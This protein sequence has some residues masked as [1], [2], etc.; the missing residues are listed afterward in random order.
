[1]EQHVDVVSVT[2]ETDALLINQY[3]RPAFLYA[4]GR[5]GGGGRQFACY[6]YDWWAASVC[7]VSEVSFHF[8]LHTT[9]WYGCF[10]G[11][12]CS[13]N[14]PSNVAAGAVSVCRSRVVCM[15]CRLSI[16]SSGIY[17]RFFFL[18]YFVH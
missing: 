8:R 4:G 10:Q 12:V 5:G 3:Q 2:G 18:M 1:M 16:P 17:I 6:V 14:D 15:V 11:T 13:I 7:S 9:F